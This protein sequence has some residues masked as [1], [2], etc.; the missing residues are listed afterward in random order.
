MYTSCATNSIML[1]V[2]R[3][4]CFP[5]VWWVLRRCKNSR[6]SEAQQLEDL[7]LQQ[8]AAS[9]RQ[10]S[11]RALECARLLPAAQQWQQQRE[12]LST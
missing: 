8:A 7:K 2:D 10:Q 5:L 9:N 12:S 11:Q 4:T 3:R 6:D 1:D